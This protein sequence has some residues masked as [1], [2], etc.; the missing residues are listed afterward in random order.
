MQANATLRA[1]RSSSFTSNFQNCFR[2]YLFSQVFLKALH[3]YEAMP[4]IPDTNF[5]IWNVSHYH[6]SQNE[7]LTVGLTCKY[8]QDIT[9]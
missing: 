3:R 7:L 6:P 1:P 9:M 8:L 4:Q 5:Q 2:K